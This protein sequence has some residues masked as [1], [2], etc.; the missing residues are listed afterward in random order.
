MILGRASTQGTAR[1]ALRDQDVVPHL[2]GGHSLPTWGR[3]REEPQSVLRAARL[4][5]SLMLVIISE[6]PARFAPFAAP[7]QQALANYGRSPLPIGVHGPGHV[8]PI[9][10]Q[11][12]EEFWPHW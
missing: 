11:A 2:E 10:E 12:R 5:L 6:L 8:V 3:C 9:D 4:G 1:P 7:F